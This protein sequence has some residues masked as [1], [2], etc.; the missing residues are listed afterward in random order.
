MGS[1]GTQTPSPHL[2]PGWQCE[3]GAQLIGHAS[4]HASAPASQH[5][6]GAQLGAAGSQLAPPGGWQTPS[7][8]VSPGGQLAQGSPPPSWQR[9]GSP[10]HTW[11]GGHCALVAQAAPPWTVEPDLT[12][13][14]PAADCAVTCQGPS[15]LGVVSR[16]ARACPPAPGCG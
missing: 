12:M 3:P 1:S 9:G 7:T 16:N 15:A 5:W 8:Q 4:L 14:P 10:A 2:S 13:G 6:P 11:P